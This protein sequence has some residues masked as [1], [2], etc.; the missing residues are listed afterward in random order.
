MQKP[1]MSFWQIWNMSFGFLGIQ[2]GWG[3]QMANMSS[4]YSYLGA[5]ADSLS[6]LWL[7][8]PVTGIIIQPLIGQSSDRLWT[9]LGRR[10]PFILAGAILASLALIMMPNSPSVWIAAGLL[11][12]LDGTINASM[13]PFRA[14]VADNLPEEQNSQGFAIQSL[15]IGL[16]GTIA[17]ALPWM[18]TNW[19]GVQ[20]EG[21]GQG[22]IPAAVRLSFY[23]GAVAFLGA[24]L[25]TVFKTTEY[26]PSESE[27]AAIR[28]R[29]FDWTLGLGDILPLIF[30][31]P[32]RMWELGLV[33]FFTWIG[34]FALWVYFP[35]AVAKNIFHAEP[36]S[37][38]MEASGSWSGF[39]FAAY[40][41]VC[42]GFSFVLLWATK[43]TGP[44]I[45]HVLCL[46]TGALGLALVPLATDKYN[47][48]ISMTA[49]GIA[50]A[51]ILSMPYA[52]LAPSLPK[53]KVG[54][55]MGMFNLFIVLPQIVASSL[56]GFM[57]KKFMHSEP[58]NALILGGVSMG[59][60]ALLTLLVVTFQKSDEPVIAGAVS[61]H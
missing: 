55:M 11:W 5:N 14:L 23:I 43:Y 52:M 9:R 33:Q 28:D 4:I 16:G 17:S 40:N 18:M 12:V 39:C 61:A 59:L 35:S 49:I 29:K 44:K 22:H 1:K 42:F 10:R 50:W 54:V 45:M 19:F 20:T 37:V 51:S 31:L 41:V 2:F 60:A 13:Q 7:A 15:F 53:S 8:A 21:A 34:M 24:V 58:M 47:L 26:P 57:L 25:W 36:G 3:L 27:L 6:I 30:H 46:A 48:L 56:L 32:R 38:A